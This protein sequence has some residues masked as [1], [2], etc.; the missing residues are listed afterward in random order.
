M[1]AVLLVHAWAHGEFMASLRHLHSAVWR[2]LGRPTA[3]MLSAEPTAMFRLLRYVASAEY[4][5]LG[6]SKMRL[7]G[8]I[9]RHSI[10]ALFL[11][12]AAGM[13]VL[14]LLGESGSTWPGEL[15]CK[16]SATLGPALESSVSACE[17]SR[18]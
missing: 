11:W 8:D 6:D 12:F 10:L 4:R 9:Q 15:A 17:S 18:P 5:E 3:T 2:R 7:Y 16:P 14:V 1:L 13:A